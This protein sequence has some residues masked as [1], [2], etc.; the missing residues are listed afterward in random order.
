MWELCGVFVEMTKPT[1]GQAL[2]QLILQKR[3]AQGLTQTQ[4]AEDAFLSSTK[5]RRISELENGT[6]ANPFPS[7]TDPIINALNISD[8]EIE[9]CVKKS[10][11]NSD[12]KLEEAYQ[13]AS[14]FLQDVAHSF[15]QQNPDASFIQLHAFLKAKAYEWNELKKK[16]ASIEEVDERIITIKEDALK[17]ISD[18]QFEQA[19]ILLAEAEEILLQEQTIIHVR[20]QMIVRI[21]RAN[22]RFLDSDYIKAEELYKSAALMLQ[23][24][25]EDEMVD[26]IHNLAGHL[27]ETSRRIGDSSIFLPIH[28]LKTLTVLDNVLNDPAKNGATQFRLALT[29]RNAVEYTTGEVKKM[30]I[31]LAINHARQAVKISEGLD[32]LYDLSSARGILG[33]C[34]LD[35]AKFNGDDETYGQCIDLLRIT[36]SDIEKSNDHA[37][38]LGVTSNSLAAAISYY[39]S[40]QKR[41]AS[42]EELKELR[43][44][45]KQSIDCLELS[46]DLN[47]WA[48]SQV[49]Y[50]NYTSQ[51]A[52][53][54]K[55]DSEK[56]HVLRIQAISAFLAGLEAYPSTKFPKQYAE[57]NYCLGKEITKQTETTDENLE[58]YLARAISHL[59]IACSFYTK[60]SD[61][62]RW[63]EI[64][65]YM[66]SIFISHA[67][68]AE[69][70]IV[71]FDY[72]QA[73]LIFENLKECDGEHKLD[74][75]E[76]SNNYLDHINEKIQSLA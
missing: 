11:K 15:D 17:L 49:N 38:L 54:I 52:G 26:F 8:A 48:G 22:A 31:D 19:D 42:T 50:G 14:H 75:I 32:S 70:E 2:G 4:L 61:L 23:P 18:G 53:T 28:L 71:E 65:I 35:F 9:E 20:K 1:F 74:L 39:I 7:T 45:F 36:L 21:T 73:Q 13:Q 57:L 27:Y 25:D 6:V 33:N 68:I 29:Y 30:T 76:I 41:A 59:E 16:L 5:T 64:Q 67:S 40:F 55:D 66:G 56:V 34:L 46:G 63:V 10:L 47:T 44:L 51:L 24:F 37:V 62:N 3:K 58:F 69:E 72:E 60:E 12:T 43:L